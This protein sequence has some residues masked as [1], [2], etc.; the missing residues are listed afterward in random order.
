MRPPELLIALTARPETLALLLLAHALLT[1]LFY[2]RARAEG[3]PRG[4]ALW[5]SVGV[6]TVLNAV[7]LVVL[8]W[9]GDGGVRHLVIDLF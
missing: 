7:A 4:L 6:Y 5:A 9:L 1:R 8:R 3:A 2:K